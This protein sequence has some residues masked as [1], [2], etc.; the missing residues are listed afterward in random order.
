MGR[1]GHMGL[2]VVCALLGACVGPGQRFGGLASATDPRSGKPT[3]VPFTSYA[4]GSDVIGDQVITFY[5][6]GAV[7]SYTLKTPTARDGSVL[8]ARTPVFDKSRNIVGWRET[9]MVAQVSSSSAWDA[10]GR[11]VRT[12]F[13]GANNFAGT[14]MTGMVG[15]EAAKQ[16]GSVGVSAVEAFKP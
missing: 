12:T 9:P 2:M 16:T 10:L 15:L 14:I 8:I 11:M 13:S 7:K 1:I 3:Q 4:V 6:G 5:P